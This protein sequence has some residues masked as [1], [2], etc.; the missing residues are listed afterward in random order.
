MIAVRASKLAWIAAA[1]MVMVAPVRAADLPGDVAAGRSIALRS[2]V[3]C[4]ALDERRPQ[5]G[6]DG[7]PSFDSLARDPAVTEISLRAFL[8]TPHSRMPDLILSNREIDDV[9]SYIFSLRQKR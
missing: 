8:Q 2:C 1:A 3:S 5:P 6:M 9:I 7:A 4:H